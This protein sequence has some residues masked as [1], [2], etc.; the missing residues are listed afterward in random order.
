MQAVTRIIESPYR[1]MT[2]PFARPAT[3]PTSMDNS[4][5]PMLRLNFSIIP[6]ETSHHH[7]R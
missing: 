1:T 2:A 3:R 5:P 6:R 7:H 4:R